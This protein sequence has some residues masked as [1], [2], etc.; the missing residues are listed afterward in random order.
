MGEKFVEEPHYVNKACLSLLAKEY[1]RLTSDEILR[2]S[3]RATTT[4]QQESINSTLW[5]RLPK[6]KYHGRKRVELAVSA[7]ILNWCQGAEAY[8]GVL[9]ELG[10]TTGKT[11]DILTRYR[12]MNRVKRSLMVPPKKKLRRLLE[13]ENDKSAYEAGGFV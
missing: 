9:Q 6:R 13:D 12:N 5:T 1:S 3:L 4:N 2:R 7:V 11:M 10:I 8:R